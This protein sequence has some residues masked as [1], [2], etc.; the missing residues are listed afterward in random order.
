MNKDEERKLT[1]IIT[2]VTSICL[3]IAVGSCAFCSV[4][5]GTT[6]PYDEM[7]E[8]VSPK[9]VNVLGIISATAF[10]LTIA[11]PIVIYLIGKKIYSKPSNKAPETKIKQGEKNNG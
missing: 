7:G 1:N 6:P 9:G 11:A 5:I 3:L 2:L 8:R 10:L 4:Q